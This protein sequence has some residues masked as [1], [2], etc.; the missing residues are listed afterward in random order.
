MNTKRHGF[1]L[2]ELLI[3]IAIISLLIS[4]IVPA[5]QSS[6][7]AARKVTCQNNMRQVALAAQQFVNSK[8]HFPTAGGNPQAFDTR[9]SA[10]GVE[11]AGWA[12][13]ILTYLEQSALYQYGHEY[14]SNED[15]PALGMR[16]TEVKIP[17]YT[18]PDRGVRESLPFGD[19]I[20]NAFIDYAGVMTDWGDQGTNETPPTEE[21]LLKAW[22]GIIAKGGHY[23]A[24]SPQGPVFY[25][26]TKV[27]PASVTDGLSTTILFMEKSARPEWYV[28]HEYWDAPSWAFNADWATM[29]LI[30]KP[31]YADA[32]PREEQDLSHEHGFGSPHVGGVV[33]AFGDGSVRTLSFD[34]RN[35][36]DFVDEDKSG[37]LRWL[38]SRDDNHVIDMKDTIE[39]EVE[40]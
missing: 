26:Y 21:N 2:I 7:S 40:E 34:L 35:H 8:G 4:L 30:R 38:G 5:V 36:F 23:K 14:P 25:Q 18:C 1:T 10:N 3:V 9:L 17:I 31:L 16:I 12:F 6:R 20:V 13:Q 24:E 37:V 32:A 27:T 33:T 15:I 28:T 22:R 19:G 29:R 39:R 11:R